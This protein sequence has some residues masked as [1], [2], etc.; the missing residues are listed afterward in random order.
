MFVIGV[1]GQAQFGKDTLADKLQ[2]SLNQFEGCNWQR[3]AFAANVKKVF[4]DTFAVDEA[5]IE[6]WKVIPEAPP[7]FDMPVRQALQFIGD[8]FRKIM[9]TIWLDLVFR[10]KAAPVI[11]SDVRYINEFLRVKEEGGCN[12]LVGRPDRLNDDQNGSEA[13]IRPFVQWCMNN[14]SPDM[15]VHDLRGLDWD[16]LRRRS[17]ASHTYPPENIEMFDFF[18]WNRLDKATLHKAIENEL[19]PEVHR[20]KFRFPEAQCQL[21][22]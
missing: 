6:K 3:A 12:I 9:G 15:V 11:V 19:M 7:G 10:N 17:V 1:A 21:S 14:L 20:F 16:N 18:V 5:F 22:A 2:E 4:M 8:G 13:Q